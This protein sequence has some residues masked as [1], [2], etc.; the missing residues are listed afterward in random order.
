MRW[1]LEAMHMSPWQYSVYY[2]Q[3]DETVVGVRTVISIYFDYI[4]YV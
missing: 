3:V 2:R 4:T 1:S